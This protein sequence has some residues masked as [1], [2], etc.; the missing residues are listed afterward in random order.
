M[1]EI[2]MDL[3]VIRT[4]NSIRNALVELIEEKG[5]E[6]ITVKD[7][8]TKA[9]INR[10]TFYAHYQDK[11]DLMTKCQEEIMQG[12]SDIAKQ[13]IPDVI[14]ELGTDSPLNKPF[15]VFVSIFEYLNVNSEFMKAALGP[16]GDLSFQ[17]KIKD[18]MLKTL[19]ENDQN[20]LIKE[21]NLLVPGHFLISY[22]ASAHI[23]VI[24][25]WLDSERKESPQEMARILSTI[26][27]NGPFFAAG[28][29]K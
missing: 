13:N 17:T 21:E 4:K 26:T 20:S 6:T 2:N 9:K 1:R 12:M 23:G 7:I 24:Q 19:F 28:L 11:F 5:F 8:T 3:R 25:Q 15:T 29:K 27:V 18:F 10:G 16:K 22:I 14:A